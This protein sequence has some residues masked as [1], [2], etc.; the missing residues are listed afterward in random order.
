MK[1]HIFAPRKTRPVRALA[2]FA[3]TVALALFATV[4]LLLPDTTV[5]S[6]DALTRVLSDLEPLAAGIFE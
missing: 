5:H 2:A 1:R 6:A 3:A 4:L